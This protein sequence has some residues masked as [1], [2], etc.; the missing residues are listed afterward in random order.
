MNED[1]LER[2]MAAFLAQEFDVLV[3]TT[4]IESGL[5]MPRVN[6]IVIDRAD[7]FGLAPLYQIRGRVGPPSPRPFAYLIP[8]PGAAPPPEE[9]LV[10]GAAAV[11]GENLPAIKPP[12]KA[13]KK[14]ERQPRMKNPLRF[15][16]VVFRFRCSWA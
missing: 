4:I 7:R 12:A 5:D 10:V 15:H 16:I 8:P 14:K 11:G 3:T 1:E 6:T 13:T 2:V 9:Y